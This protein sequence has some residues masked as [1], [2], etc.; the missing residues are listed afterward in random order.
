MDQNSMNM[1]QSRS[2]TEPYVHSMRSV[3]KA[4]VARHQGAR[5]NYERYLAQART[6]ALIGNQIEAENFYQHAEHYFRSFNQYEN[7]RKLIA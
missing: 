3:K 2:A 4:A 7:S 1:N 5:L 6:Q